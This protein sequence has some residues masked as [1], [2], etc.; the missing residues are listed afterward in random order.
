MALDFAAELYADDAA[1]EKFGRGEVEQF[2]DFLAATL[3]GIGIGDDEVGDDFGGLHG[4]LVEA[5]DAGAVGGAFLSGGLL[6]S[7]V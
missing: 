6:F 5:G 1:F 4:E 7:G 2:G 3:K